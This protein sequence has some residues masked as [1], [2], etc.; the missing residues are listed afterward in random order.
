MPELVV[1]PHW[2]LCTVAE[3]VLRSSDSHVSLHLREH[4]LDLVLL[5]LQELPKLA[6]IEHDLS[7]FPRWLFAAFTL[8]AFF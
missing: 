7:W 2:F 1:I 4:I 3:G 8:N 6:F 5:K